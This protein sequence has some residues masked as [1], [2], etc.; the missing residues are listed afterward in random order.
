MVTMEVGPETP[1]LKDQGEMGKLAQKSRKESQQG[2]TERKM[3]LEV[4][5]NTFNMVG[6]TIGVKY[7]LMA[8]GLLDS[9]KSSFR[10]PAVVVHAFN[11]STWKAEA[12]GFLSS[13]PAWS[14][15]RVP[16]QPGLHRETRKKKKTKNKTNKNKN[17]FWIVLKL[18][19]LGIRAVRVWLEP[20]E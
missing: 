7:S 13:R 20:S 4:T 18:L 17:S 10:C 1:V 11:P 9:V 8:S 16:G 3:F 12:G 15:E 5:I 14:T 6:V 2:S 19:S